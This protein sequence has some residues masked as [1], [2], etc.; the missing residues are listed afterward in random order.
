MKE[1]K[2]SKLKRKRADVAVKANTAS[3]GRTNKPLAI[4]RNALIE[5]LRLAAHR[6]PYLMP[7]YAAVV[8]HNCNC[9][10][11]RQGCEEFD[12]SEGEAIIAIICDD[13]E[14]GDSMGP[15]SFPLASVERYFDSCAAIAMTSGGVQP[16]LYAG[17]A[18]FAAKHRKNVALIETGDAFDMF[19]VHLIRTRAPEMNITYSPA[20][21]TQAEK[22]RRH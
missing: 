15:E 4:E 1:M 18:E 2:P 21:M 8:E 20:V 17:S 19:W 6:S 9:I 16:G 5:M 13:P 14:G 12:V 3:D 7:I 11:V 10:F 22:G